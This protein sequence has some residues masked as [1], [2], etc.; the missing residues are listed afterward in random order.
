M[1]W[2]SEPS[3]RGGCM[4]MIKVFLKDFI[5]RRRA[6]WSVIAL[7]L[8][9]VI[10]AAFQLPKFA[11]ASIAGTIGIMVC[12]FPTMY[13]IYTYAV[14]EHIRLYLTMP[15]SNWK[16]ILSFVLALFVQTLLE[17]IAFVVLVI[18]FLFENPLPII[19]F[20]I[21]SGL[22]TVL[23]N[24]VILL[25][26]NSKKAVA[27]I[28]GLLLFAG[29]I[30]VCVLVGSLPLQLGLVAAIG[31]MSV[32]LML[33]HGGEDLMVR[34]AGAKTSGF[35]RN[36]FWSVLLSEKMYLL[37]T[38]MV[39]AFAGV[40]LF[41]F[42]ERGNPIME[43]IPWVVAAVNTPVTTMLSGDKWLVR[44]SEMLPDQHGAIM[45]MYRRFLA[46]YFTATNL[47][48]LMLCIAH[49]S[50]FSLY[51]VIQFLAAVIIEIG[52]ASY[53]ETKQRITDWQTKQQLW[54]NPRKYIMPV[55]VFIACCAIGMVS[56]VL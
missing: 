25:G 7:A 49:A 34:R 10:L 47:I 4:S 31:A 23:L 11:L 20:L 1:A 3:L 5:T 36:Y 22:V 44:Q 8:V 38:A 33:R 15:V 30:A 24:V 21:C 42:A 9:A 27:C 54:R 35:G 13:T 52:L 53:L 48:V 12:F 41:G 45:G 55:A 16:I 50:H 43:C 29:L 32:L 37:N 39:V 51:L 6:A 56:A 14:P 2:T 40:F 26:M 18:G 19:T 46:V 17:R 28:A